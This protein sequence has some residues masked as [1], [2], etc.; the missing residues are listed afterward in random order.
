MKRTAVILSLA[1]L[2]TLAAIAAHPAAAQNT[3]A[4]ASGAT[5]T[6]ARQEY[7]QGISFPHHLLDRALEPNVGKDG[8]VDYVALKGDKNLV[9]YL[10]AVAGADLSKFPVF[11]VPPKID[12][13]TG[14]P[15][16]GAKPTESR[17]AEMV[18]WIN[19]YN[20]HIL[21]R[22]ASAYPIS[23]PDEVKDLDTAKVHRVAGQ[24]WNLRD[25]RKKVTSF[26]PRALFTL[27]NGTLGGPLLQPIAY[28]FSG[29]DQ[30]LENAVQT[31]IDDPRN[32]E[33]LRINNKVTLNSYFS[34]FNEAF[35]PNS[36]PKKMVGVRFLLSSYSRRR[37][38]RSY[39]TTS[40]YTI[41]TKKSDRALNI[42]ANDLSVTSG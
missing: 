21:N 8:R 26:D 12:E 28:R 22:L 16:E 27:T 31:F 38:E 29:I 13:R 33:V 42:K 36:D 10:E 25:M 40:D 32:V 20:A 14:K 3:G 30:Q 35:A 4:D 34:E 11:P 24:D 9:A 2:S 37:A 15:A 6:A 19:A 5:S 23:S 7:G 17:N 39:F 41:D 1:G 18:F